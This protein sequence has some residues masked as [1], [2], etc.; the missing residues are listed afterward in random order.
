[1][2]KSK[3]YQNTDSA[4]KLP[5]YVD[6]QRNVITR[7]AINIPTLTWPDGS[8]CLQGNVYMLELFHRGLSRR[9]NGGTLLSYATNISHLLRYVYKNNID[10]IH[11]T[12]N[13]FSMFMRFL[14]GEKRESQPEV[15][16]RNSNGVI[17]IGRNCLDFLA[18]LGRLYNDENF[19]GPNGQIRAEQ[20]EYEV[21]HGRRG[22]AKIFRRY[23]HHRSFP[24]ADPKNKRLP[25][26]NINVEKLRQ[27]IQ[28][29]SGTTSLKKRRYV[30]LK[31][32]EVTGGRR[33]ELVELTC[34]SVV[35]AS[36]MA[37]PYLRML[38]TKKRNGNNEYRD[39]PIAKHDVAYLM[40]YIEVNRKRVIRLTCGHEKDDGF[41]L[42][43]D[44]TG[45]GLR[46]NTITQE[47]SMLTKLAGVKEKACP[48][49]FR[50][51]FITKLFVALIE[52][53]E[54]EN[55]DSFRRALLDIETIKQKIQQLTGH[56]RLSS[57]DV[58]IDLAFDEVT[59]FKKTFDIV[60]AKHVLKSFQS[61][62]SQFQDEIKNGGSLAEISAR[63]EKSIGAL[64]EDL[65]RLQYED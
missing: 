14:Q 50:H 62:L 18:C 57:L 56:T 9:N 1:M 31:L 10:L 55:T 2:T 12:D 63:L 39:I 30:M 44:T 49:M 13:E 7:E 41:L 60:N 52:Q 33:S 16:A 26:S 20:K 22:Q 46:A 48:H 3:L 47:I 36:K 37:E 53:H 54:F 64:K 42:V 23:W 15:F 5:L 19:V 24:V 61:T 4:F 6:T 32:L 38:T 59:N 29:A 65:D 45:K 35:M 58:Y 27:E 34:E 25:I 17:A 43:S 8:W 28:K 51:R 21:N 11:L 40:E